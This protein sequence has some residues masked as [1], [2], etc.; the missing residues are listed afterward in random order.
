MIEE[1]AEFFSATFIVFFSPNFSYLTNVRFVHWN[2][3]LL[4]TLSRYCLKVK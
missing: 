3:L 1:R 4:Q 2:A